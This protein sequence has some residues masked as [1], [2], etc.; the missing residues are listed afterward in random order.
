MMHLIS[1][2]QLKAV[3]LIWLITIPVIPYD[4]LGYVKPVKQSKMERYWHFKID[5]TEVLQIMSECCVC[6]SGDESGLSDNSNLDHT[7][8]GRLVH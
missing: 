4:A 2:T 8:P 1:K 6:F 7:L 5:E 3:H